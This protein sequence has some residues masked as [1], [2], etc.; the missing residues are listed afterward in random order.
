MDK[1][2][3]RKALTHRDKQLKMS[4]KIFAK[5]FEYGNRLLLERGETELSYDDIKYKTTVS[6]IRA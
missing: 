2:Q 3:W 4:K 5:L 6:S 1:V